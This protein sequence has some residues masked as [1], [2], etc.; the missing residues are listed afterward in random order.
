MASVTVS[1]VIDADVDDVVAAMND[2]EPFV[3]SA[4][5]DEVR[6]DGAEIRVAKDM[7]PMRIE[8]TLAEA[9]DPDAAVVHVQREGI[10]EHMRTEYRVAEVDGRVEVTGE[11]EFALD[12]AVVGPVLDAT[13][14]RRVRRTELNNQFD[15]L[16]ERAGDG[17]DATSAGDGGGADGG[18]G[19][20][21]GP[22]SGGEAAG[23]GDDGG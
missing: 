12:A 9:D 3:R 6:Y 2:V 1:R 11:T 10:F 22:G 13:V 7:G 17:P 14:I 18:E 23:G 20:S 8:L 4:G 15:Y 21:D 19:P 16:Q 5:F